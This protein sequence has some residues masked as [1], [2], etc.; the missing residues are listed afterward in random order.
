[1][2][3]PHTII[4]ILVVCGLLYKIVQSYRNAVSLGIIITLLW[5]LLLAVVVLL[6]GGV[7]W[8]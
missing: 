1:M 6:Y 8:W 5:L 3:A 4:F 7:V 2:I